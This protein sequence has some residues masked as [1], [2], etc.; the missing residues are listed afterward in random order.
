MEAYRE[1][2][3]W[4]ATPGEVSAVAGLGLARALLE[5]GRP[6]EAAEQFETMARVNVDAEIL[7]PALAGAAESHEAAGQSEEAVAALRRLVSDYPDTY[8]AVLARERLRTYALTDSLAVSGA[9][10]DS[11]GAAEDTPGTPEH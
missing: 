4:G 10:A 11:L 7:A 1:I 5:M 9:D 8:E 3:D 6:G 2:A